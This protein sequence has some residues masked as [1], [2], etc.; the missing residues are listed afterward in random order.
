MRGTGQQGR[1][2][3]KEYKAVC[4]PGGQGFGREHS[5]LQRSHRTS[6]S[7]NNSRGRRKGEH[8]AKKAGQGIYLQAFSVSVSFFSLVKVCQKLVRGA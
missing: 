3:G 7:E 2:E 1:Q 4:C 8:R 6:G 5:C